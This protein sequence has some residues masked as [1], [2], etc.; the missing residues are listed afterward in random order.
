M[1]KK[2]GEAL[3]PMDGWSSSVVSQQIEEGAACHQTMSLEIDPFSTAARFFT[4]F[5]QYGVFCKEMIKGSSQGD[6]PE[7][8][9]CVVMGGDVNRCPLYGATA[10]GESHGEHEKLRKLNELQQSVKESLVYQS[11]GNI[12]VL[13]NDG[14]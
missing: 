12:N 6:A 14:E 7:H 9:Q 10:K 4:M 11:F 13:R 1:A 8:A 2:G 3:V 5:S